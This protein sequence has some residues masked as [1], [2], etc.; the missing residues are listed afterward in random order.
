LKTAGY[1]SSVLAFALILSVAG[2]P[3]RNHEFRPG[4]SKA[5]LKL[6]G[7]IAI[8]GNPLLSSDIACRSKFFITNG[9]CYLSKLMLDGR[10][11]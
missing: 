1:F 3:A 9:K 10:S 2:R 5:P 7:V 4:G 8:P 6:I 11:R